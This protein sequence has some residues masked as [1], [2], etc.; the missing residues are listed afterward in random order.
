[1]VKLRLFLSDVGIG[2]KEVWRIAEGNPHFHPGRVQHSVNW[3]L[4]TNVYGGSFLY[5]MNPDLV[6]IG[7]VVGLDYE[8]PYIN[9]YEEFQKFKTHKEIRKI[10]E[11]GECL[12]YGARCIN[13]GGYH[14]IPKLT[15]PGGLLVGDSAGF[16]DVAKIKGSHNAIKSGI[17][18]A[19]S[20]FN[21]VSQGQEIAK[22]ELKDYETTVRGSAFTKELYKSRNFKTGFDRGLWFGLAHGRL[23][24]ITKGREPWTLVHKV[25]DSQA[26]KPKVEF[27]P[28]Q[29]PKHDGTLTF[30]L[31]TNLTRSGTNHEH[32]QPSHLKVSSYNL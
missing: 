26:T 16:L 18:A 13:E 15:F 31:L 1:M 27:K 11:G 29:Y 25:K 7:L 9:P 17:M 28:I 2:L 14:A 21:R 24:T 30:D 6:H 3:P 8:N 32:D 20:I 22:E 4:P 5:H 23:T 12:S 19:N 10:L